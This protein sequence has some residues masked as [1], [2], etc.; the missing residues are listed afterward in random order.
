[1]KW[2][3]KLAKNTNVMGLKLAENTEKF[4]PIQANC[5]RFA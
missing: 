5:P 1:M 2:V 3:K 4:N